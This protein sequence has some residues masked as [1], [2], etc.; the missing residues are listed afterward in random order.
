[1]S[2]LQL[3]LF[4]GKRLGLVYTDENGQEKHPT[5]LHR[6][7]T[8]SIERTLGILIEHFAGAFPLWLAPVQI[9]VI[10]VSDKFIKEAKVIEDKLKDNE[11]RVELNDERESVGKKIRQSTLQKVPYMVII[12]EKEAKNLEFVSVRTREGKDLGLTNFKDFVNHLKDDVQK[13]K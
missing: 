4:M 10:P 12:G 11:L 3:D 9:S 5:I 1:M 7:L 8:G 6:G 2:T 13:Q